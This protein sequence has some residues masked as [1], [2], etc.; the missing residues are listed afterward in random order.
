MVEKAT[1]KDV[2]N[3]IKYSNAIVAFGL[4]FYNN[5]LEPIGYLSVFPTREPQFVFG[6]YGKNDLSSVVARYRNCKIVG[7]E[8]DE[9]VKYHLLY[10]YALFCL[11]FLI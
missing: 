3:L 4:R 10:S 7:E 1:I 6:A 2:W 8:T 5:K 9:F 11:L